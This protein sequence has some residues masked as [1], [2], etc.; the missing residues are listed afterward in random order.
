LLLGDLLGAEAPLSVGENPE[1]VARQLGSVHLIVVAKEGHLSIEASVKFGVKKFEAGEFIVSV[2]LREALLALA[3][4]AFESSDPYEATVTQEH[5]HESSKRDTNARASGEAA[6]GAKIG[7]GKYLNFGAWGKASASKTNETNVES[8]SDYSIIIAEP[9]DT[10]RIG[11]PLGDPRHPAGATE[12][13]VEHCLHGEYFSGSGGEVGRGH[14]S[15]AGRKALCRLDPK[16]NPVGINDQRITA[17]LFGAPDSL[18]VALKRKAESPPAAD[19]KVSQHEKDLREMIIQIC[20]A[21]G[22]DEERTGSSQDARLTGEFFLGT[23]TI[24]APKIS[25]PARRSVSES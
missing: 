20:I 17:S 7:L 4:P 1:K 6:V 23:H 9:H 16:P 11:S 5:Y 22:L 3:H 24:L 13:G 25:R 12:K 21:Q 18:R 10:W 8:K 15:R 14:E 2:G 19:P